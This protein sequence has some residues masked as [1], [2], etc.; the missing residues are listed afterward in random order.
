MRRT[1]N[2]D[3]GCGGQPR[4]RRDL[5]KTHTITTTRQSSQR[6]KMENTLLYRGNLLG[7]TNKEDC[8]VAAVLGKLLG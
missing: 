7:D 8:C 6:A 4:C 2:A 5:A 3:G 1:P